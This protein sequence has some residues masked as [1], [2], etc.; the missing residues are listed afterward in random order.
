MEK[1]DQTE[2]GDLKVFE[3]L[4]DFHQPE[5]FVIISNFYETFVLQFISKRLSF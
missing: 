1:I 5:T 3:C 2:N 4:C